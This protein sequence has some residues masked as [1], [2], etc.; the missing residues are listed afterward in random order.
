M[1][2]SSPTDLQAVMETVADAAR[3][4]GGRHRALSSRGDVSTTVARVGDASGRSMRPGPPGMAGRIGRAVLDAQPGPR[5]P[6]SLDNAAASPGYG[7]GSSGLGVP[8]PLAVPLLRDGTAIG[9]ITIRRPEVR[10]FTDTLVAL[11]QTFADQAV[12][13]IE[14]VRLFQELEARNR[15]LTEALEQQTATAEVLQVISRSPTDVQPVL[16]TI[17][18]VSV[19]PAVRGR[20]A[21]LSFEGD[22]SPGRPIADLTGGGSRRFL[23]GY[24]LAAG[25]DSCRTGDVRPASCAYPRPGGFRTYRDAPHLARDAGAEAVVAVPLLRDGRAIGAIGV[26]RGSGAVHRQPD[27]PAADLRRPG[28]H[29]HRER[30]AVRGA[31]G[32]ER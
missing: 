14:N 9:A 23:R 22:G 5:P 21:A 19:R 30:A 8:E 16:D 24:P 32:E 6:G 20:R 28:R 7:A 27:R 18:G 26:P 13:A 2:S 12:I 15:E 29:R 3:L 1:I 4:C 25:P 10:P 11:L 31:P 17:A